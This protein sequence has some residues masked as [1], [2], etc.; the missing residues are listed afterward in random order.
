MDKP[1]QDSIMYMDEIYEI[2]ES[3]RQELEHDLD[4]EYNEQNRLT[5]MA[6]QGELVHLYRLIISKWL[7]K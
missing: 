7:D 3:R 2:F 1:E 4:G 5:I 6:K